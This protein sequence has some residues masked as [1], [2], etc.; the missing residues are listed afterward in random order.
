[1]QVINIDKNDV[2]K[3][4]YFVLSIVQNAN[5][6][7]HSRIGSKND[8]MGGII[9]RYVN[10]VTES[11]VFSKMLFP[12][13]KTTKK[14]DLIRD[15]YSY[16]PSI[17]TIAPDLF[18]IMVN[19]NPIPFVVY[20]EGWKPVPGCPQ[21]EIK[22][23]KKK[24]RML[25]LVNQHY[26]EKYLIL[27]ESDYKTD[28]LM[29]FINTELFNDQLYNDILNDINSYN[30]EIII[31]DH[32]G[33]I[34]PMKKVDFSSNSLGKLNI[35]AVTKTKQFIEASNIAGKGITPECIEMKELVKNQKE[36]PVP[37]I[38]FC[39]EL[40]DK[41]YRFND[42]WYALTNKDGIMYRPKNKIVT[43]DF[44]CSNIN[45]IQFIKMNKSN[46]YIRVNERTTLNNETLNPGDY[47]IYLFS[48]FDRS[49][50]N[51]EEYFIDKNLYYRIGNCE[52]ELLKEIQA[53][54]DKV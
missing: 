34:T 14:I 20:D 1:M 5:G 3:Q 6:P 15:F 40:N 8:Y 46:F 38:N 48:G 51:N 32:N 9:D 21:V 23:L 13:I 10:T 35:I 26:D 22:T 25:S 47:R 49:D 53:I 52:E 28:Y 41:F 4:M 27:V 18:G 29:P 16:D 30:D 54:I 33:Y 39:D 45:S 7:M 37:M 31:S 44:Y 17:A 42:N 50:T 11:L 12:K 24:Q 43:L 19:G 2:L 36:E